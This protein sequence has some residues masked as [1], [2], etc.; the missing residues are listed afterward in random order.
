MK[1]A[2]IWSQTVLALQDLR[3]E[4]DRSQVIAIHR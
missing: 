1:Y 4:L 2:T 3:L